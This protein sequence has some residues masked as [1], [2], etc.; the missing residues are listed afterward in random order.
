LATVPEVGLGHLFLLP[1]MTEMEEQTGALKEE[2]LL[3]PKAGSHSVPLCYCRMKNRFE[4]AFS[5]NF[6]GKKTKKKTCFPFT[7]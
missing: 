7:V 3:K 1:S 5:M 6:W 4:I 2:F